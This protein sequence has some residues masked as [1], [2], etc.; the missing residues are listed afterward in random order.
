LFQ[1]VF[2]KIGARNIPRRRTQMFLIVFALMLSTTL[3]ASVLAS[4][5][6]LNSAIQSVAVYNWGSVDELV[7]GGRGTLG[8][9]SERV[10]QRVQRRAKQND[11]I[12]AVGG[13]FR[14]T[15]LLV[16]DQ[17]S[18]QVR[19][20]VTA[21][22][23][24]PG[25]EAGFGGMI[26]QVSK[27]HRSIT[28]LGKNEVYLNLTSAQL[29][30]AHRG[31]TLYLYAQRWPGRRYQ[32]RVAGIVGN[33]GLVG[34]TPYLLSQATLFQQ[35]ENAPGQINQIYIANSGKSGINDVA[36]T[37]E[38]S[39]TLK[40]WLPRGIYS[41][42][43][44]QQGVQVA[45]TAQELFA[46]VFSL[47]ALFALSIG[48]LLIFLIFVLLAAERRSEM[49]MARAIGV[50][51]RHLILM[52]LFEGTIYDLLSSFIGVLAGVAVGAAMV[53]LLG[54]ILARF[55]FPLQLTLQPDSLIIAYCLGVIFTFLSVAIS[56]WL[57]S[58]MTVVEA[59]RDLPEPSHIPQ[60]PR[61]LGVRLL[62]L[63]DQLGNAI[64]GKGN[65]VVTTPQ[66]SS[67]TIS[68]TARIRQARL[69]RIRHIVLEQIPD[70][71]VD[72]IRTVTRLGFVPLLAGIWLMQWGLDQ[73]QI[74]P[75]SLGLSLLVIGS[76]LLLR[77]LVR[78][79]I[80]Q[81]YYWSKLPE[82]RLGTARQRAF[83]RSISPFAAIV[84]GALV[85]Y[86][87]LPF[88]VLGQFAL[89]RFQGGIEVFFVAG[90]MMVLGATW[91]LIA[92]ASLLAQ[93]LLALCAKFPN[94]YAAAKL[95]SAYPLQRRFRT[96]LSV[97]MFGL[98]VFAMTVMAVI[99]SAM[100]SNYVD[101]S[102]QTG[103][104]D[105]QGTPYFK[106][107]GDINS[108]LRQHGFKPQQFA[109][110]GERKTTAVGVLQLSAPS[111]RWSI[112]PAQIVSGGFLQGYG[113][114]L[115]ARA[116][117]FTSDSAIWQALQTHSNYAL[118][119][120]SSLQYN[121]KTSNNSVYDPSA[122]QASSATVPTSPPGINTNYAFRMSGV[123]QGE[124][125]FPATPLWV[126]GLQEK[127][128]IKLTVIG[129]VDNSDA[130]HFGLYIPSSASNLANLDTGTSVP[131]I[132]GISTGATT[133]GTPATNSYYF[134][135]AP[136]QDPHTMALALG[137]AFLNNG[138]ETTV[139]S[140][141][142]WQVRGPRILLSD[143]L[144]GVVGMTLL[145]GVAALAITGTRAVVERRQQIGMLRALGC[146]RGLIQSAF[147]LESFL[148]GVAG[149]ILGIVLGLLLAK[150]IF[151]AN[152][153]EQYQTGLSY[154]IPWQELGVIVIVALIAS[155]LGAILPAW[156][157]GRITPAEALRYQ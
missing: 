79:G 143:L 140:D 123:Y 11:A 130:A 40:R 146:K 83:L 120:S 89:P 114:H 62:T 70:V 87:A 105:I 101:I 71:L 144:L 18:R 94:L 149:S 28:A 61:D 104:Y 35:I 121:F 64:R 90:I 135:V 1:R 141:L 127:Q 14:E 107:L 63:F 15:N 86:W 117:G 134:K 98:V 157:A 25:S 129:V 142:V 59:L 91:A 36:L 49:G 39:A 138:F 73:V 76:A 97:I 77:A 4:G 19:S 147:L 38:V 82:N 109:A 154:V 153:F 57:V 65:W 151:A 81:F 37:N 5:D 55:N 124:S 3:L 52:F 21:L 122:S 152:F 113:L 43:V 46:R 85:A 78:M 56:S 41:I 88:N 9:F 148:V 60:T 96:G 48:L 139:L 103:G 156:Q 13:V 42:P 72:L 6:V 23:I 102:R 16:A 53:K 51:R 7:Q 58:R 133:L 145:L 92:N 34:D 47:F 44:K 115:T 80:R 17:S 67:S 75:F 112:Y 22:G 45:E 126:V 128:A 136:G 29:L 137:S 95:A 110:I 119:D 131:G 111:P 24:V 100:Q 116:Q 99:T 32:V 31:D 8:T 68:S 54:P 30:N 26:D 118:I 106:S 84:G 108:A 12:A 132:P 93:P 66:S 20:S 33:N 150:N 2:F 27:Q 74:I 125:S 69:R 155:F 50:Q 10:Y